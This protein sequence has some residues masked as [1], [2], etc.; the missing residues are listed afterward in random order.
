MTTGVERE[1]RRFAQGRYI[2]TLDWSPDGNSLV[3]DLALQATGPV[4]PLQQ[5]RPETNQIFT[6]QAN[7]ANLRLVRGNGNGTPAWR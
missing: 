5:G 4:G 3:F 7:G 1:V 2:T 6:I